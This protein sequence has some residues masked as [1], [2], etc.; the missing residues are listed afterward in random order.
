LADYLSTFLPCAIS[1]AELGYYLFIDI[2]CVVVESLS[3]TGIAHT[4][5]HHVQQ[6]QIRSLNVHGDEPG[7]GKVGG[8]GAVFLVMG[9]VTLQVN[10]VDTFPSD[11]QME[12]HFHIC[13]P[14][15]E[16]LLFLNFCRK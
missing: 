3:I 14:Y 1:S 5:I 11:D 8:V 10:C 4:T 9:R 7:S 16:I 12:D 2:C 15:D 13:T 6:C